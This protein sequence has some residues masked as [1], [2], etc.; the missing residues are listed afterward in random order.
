MK[1]IRADFRPLIMIVDDLTEGMQMVGNVIRR[2]CE[3]DL[4]FAGGGR[5]ALVTIGKMLDK[6]IVPDLI[7]L[8]VIMPDINGYEV[9]RQLKGDDRICD[10]PVIFLTAKGDSEDVLTGF[11]AG[12][13]DYV[14]K[15]FV[16]AELVA[17]VRTQLYIRRQNSFRK[18]MLHVLCHDLLNPFGAMV[19]CIDVIEDFSMYLKFRDSLKSL[20]QT[21]IDII[22]LSR[23]LRNLEDKSLKT[24]E[25]P[26][27]LRSLVEKSY[28]A[29]Q[30]QY[31]RKNVIFINA[32]GPDVMVKVERNYFVDLVLANLLSNAVKFSTPGNK[33]V[34]SA[35]RTGGLVQL[36][37]RDEGVGM[38]EAIC[39]DLFDIRR[40][41]NR[42]GTEGETGNGL[43]LPLSAKIVDQLGGQMLVWSEVG[44]GTLMRVELPDGSGEDNKEEPNGKLIRQ[45]KEIR[46]ATRP[47]GAAE[48][49]SALRREYMKT[50]AELQQVFL[51]NRLDEMVHDLAATALREQC[52]VLA[53][54]AARMLTAIDQVDFCQCHEAL[55]DFPELLDRIK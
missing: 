6:G 7:L 48:L 47:E 54:Y 29:V 41:T 15:P 52:G 8:D 23:H 12:A 13:V 44:K 39:R 9:C 2:N 22:G 3:C 32:V 10:V 14:P 16:P 25:T 43:G 26:S 35:V 30:E 11:N 17:R 50:A 4:T 46:S 5:E 19:S 45:L 28:V 53:E 49:A 20:A 40:P 38:P 21:G 34:I 55:E 42:P 51:L 33:V 36:D 24:D 18:E 37:C 31:E 1:M 27:P